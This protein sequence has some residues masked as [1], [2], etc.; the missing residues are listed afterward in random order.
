VLPILRKLFRRPPIRMG[1]VDNRTLRTTPIR[2]A[3]FVSF[4]ADNGCV[5]PRR[6][7]VVERR[8]RRQ[9]VWR[10]LATVA[11][12]TLSVWFVVESAYALA[13]F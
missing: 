2:N 12:V 10:A 5:S 3:G 1:S 9:R 11:V 6:P 4:F 8:M 7:H 13:S